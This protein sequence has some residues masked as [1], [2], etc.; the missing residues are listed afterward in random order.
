MNTVFR[1][2]W[3]AAILGLVVFVNR[4]TPSSSE[5]SAD[6][7]RCELDPPRDLAGLE[8]CAARSPRDVE[9]LVQLAAAYEAAGRRDDA[10]TAYRRAIEIDPRDADAQR[11]LA[12]AR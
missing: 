9:L 11:R 4:Y 3:T 2:I 7:V 12:A 1:L 6:S 10:R 8:A 5:T